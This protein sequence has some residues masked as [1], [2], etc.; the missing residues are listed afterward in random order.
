MADKIAFSHKVSLG[1]MP[2]ITNTLSLLQAC[3]KVQKQV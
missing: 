3:S 1:N 2:G